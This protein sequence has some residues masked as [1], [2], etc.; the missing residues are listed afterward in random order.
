MW[1]SV[2]VISILIWQKIWS[3]LEVG[4]SNHLW[5][6]AWV[7][8]GW[9]ET[10][11]QVLL[12]FSCYAATAQWLSQ[13]PP[14]LPPPP[15]PTTRCR[16]VLQP[17]AEAT[18]PPG[19]GH[20]RDSQRTVLL[21]HVQLRSR[22]GDG[23]QAAFGEQA[24]QSQSVRAEVPPRD[25]EPRLQLRATWAGRHIW[26]RSGGEAAPSSVWKDSRDPAAIRSS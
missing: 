23:L 1:F 22:A 6:I 7:Y 4:I 18:H 12:P 2:G 11:D 10:K 26:W 15:E 21:L 3:K 5:I 9:L 16:A 20:V 25:G 14:P 19:P 13:W 8:V 24:A 17:Q